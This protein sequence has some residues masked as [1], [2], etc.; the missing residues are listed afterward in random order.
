MARFEKL[1]EEMDALEKEI[2]EKLKKAPQKKIKSVLKIKYP[3][4]KNLISVLSSIPK[5]TLKKLGLK[6][7]NLPKPMI[8]PNTIEEETEETKELR[9]LEK[10]IEIKPYARWFLIPIR[11]KFTEELIR[12]LAYREGVIPEIFLLK[13]ILQGFIRIYAKKHR[14]FLLKNG[15]SFVVPEIDRDLKWEVKFYEGLKKHSSS[16]LLSR[17]FFLVMQNSYIYSTRSRYKKNPEI[18][19]FPDLIMKE[20]ENLLRPFHWHNASQNTVVTPDYI[21]QYQIIEWMYIKLNSP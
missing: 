12:D 2:I 20:N 5:Q 21:D 18:T 17:R 3:S 14:N 6:P 4:F 10:A 19:C 7:A 1:I 11:F 9:E 16:Y 13:L 15:Y 8:I